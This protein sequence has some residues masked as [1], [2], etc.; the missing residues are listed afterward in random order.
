LVITTAKTIKANK[1][2]ARLADC[3]MRFV[4]HRKSLQMNISIHVA[5]GVN[6]AN[7]K[8][9]GQ[10][11]Q[12]RTIEQKVEDMICLFRKLDTPR[13]KDVLKFIDDHGGAKVC[14]SN[15]ELLEELVAKSG[16]S[17]SRVS[18]RES[19][20]RP[21]NLLDIKKKLVKELQEDMDEAFSRNLV[22]FERKLDV[23]SKQL[24]DTVRQESDHIISTLMSGAHDRITDPVR[25]FLHERSQVIS[26]RHTG[27]PE[28]L[29]GYGS[30]FC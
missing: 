19:G 11:Y 13:E 1:Y 4:E 28:D 3:G 9:D 17:L 6:S 15:D 26:N 16:E 20:R 8:L 30:S 18:G 27:S 7:I 21:N 2:E 14:I 25:Q 24:A 5:V 10:H 22:M 23:Q 29:E 12:L